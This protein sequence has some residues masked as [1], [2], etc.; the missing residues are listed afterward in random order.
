MT[1]T[2][3]DICGS[4]N[5]TSPEDGLTVLYRTID[6][7]DTL[8][9]KMS[10]WSQRCGPCIDLCTKCRVEMQESLAEMILKMK[11]P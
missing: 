5:T 8:E 1:K 7:G 2:F 6:T 11:N 4:E 3:C 9:F 10:Q